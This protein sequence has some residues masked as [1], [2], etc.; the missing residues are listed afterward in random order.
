MAKKTGKTIPAFPN[1]FPYNELLLRGKLSAKTRSWRWSHTGLTLLYTSTSTARDVTAAYGLDPKIASR[2]VLVGVG[3]LLPVRL[4]T[5]AEARKIER[6]FSN[7]GKWAVAV[8]AGPYRYKF[9]NLR[10][11]KKPVPFRPPRGAVRTFNVPLSV[12]KKSLKEIGIS[13]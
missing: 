1:S 2:G 13:V 5:I 10:R 4:V 8:V 12:V 9:K 3:E 7:N 11:F 6:E